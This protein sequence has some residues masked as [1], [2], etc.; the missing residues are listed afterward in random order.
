MLRG[1]Q[2]TLPY[3]VSCKAVSFSGFKENDNYVAADLCRLVGVARLDPIQ[4][5]FLDNFLRLPAECL[6]VMSA[7]F[8]FPDTN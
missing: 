4:D 3:C 1:T 2:S 8:V 7:Q 6:A 5:A